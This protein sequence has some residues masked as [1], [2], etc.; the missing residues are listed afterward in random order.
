MPKQSRQGETYEVVKARYIKSMLQNCV[1]YD[2]STTLERDLG[3]YENY[4][5]NNQFW[6]NCKEVDQ[7][8]SDGSQTD[9]SFMEEFENTSNQFLKYIE[10]NAEQHIIQMEPLLQMLKYRRI[11]EKTTIS[12]EQI[13]VY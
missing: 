7:M 13:T 10:I 9:K 8:I 3:Q 5:V 12:L 6:Q 1:M 4:G 2:H 11:I